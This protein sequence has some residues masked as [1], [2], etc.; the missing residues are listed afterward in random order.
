LAEVTYCWRYLIGKKEYSISGGSDSSQNHY[1]LDEAPIEPVFFGASDAAFADDPETRR[2]SQGYIFKLFGMPVDWKANVQR[3]VTKSTTEA[4][5][6]ALSLAGGELAWWKR[7]FRDL[8][9]SI[10]STPTLWCDNQQTVGVV[11]KASELLQTKLKHVDI[12]QHWLRQEV[13]AGRLSV[14]WKATNLMPADGLTKV[15]PR[16]KHV[17]FIK[18]LGLADFKQGLEETNGIEGDLPDP[19]DLL[20]WY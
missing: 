4:E 16:Q 15:L 12:H 5:F 9:L 8:K 13:Q 20:R 10:G 18:L 6:M 1:L 14:E 19:Q 11:N 7:F 17:Q 2:S 3:S